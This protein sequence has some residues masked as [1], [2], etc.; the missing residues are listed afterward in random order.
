M[1]KINIIKNRFLVLAIILSTC[2]LIGIIM[3]VFGAVF[4]IVEILAVGITIF[5]MS[6]YSTPF[7]WTTFAKKCKDKKIIFKILAGNLDL[8]NL[9]SCFNMVYRKF[10]S[11]VEFLVINNYLV[12]YKFVGN[13][14]LIKLGLTKCSVCGGDINQEKTRNICPYCKT[15]N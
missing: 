4:W 14:N 5:V 9:A 3:I 12:G 7:V 8:K 13:D 2:I 6:F 10:K 1:K 11:R 15:I